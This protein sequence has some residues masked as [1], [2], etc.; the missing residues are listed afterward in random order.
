VSNDKSSYAKNND[1]T[2]S[3]Q[4]SWSLELTKSKINNVD[5][6]SRPKLSSSRLFSQ[7]ES[8]A[9][10]HN[11]HD[12]N[13]SFGVEASKSESLS[14]KSTSLVDDPNVGKLLHAGKKPAATKS[15]SDNNDP[16]RGNS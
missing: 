10:Q 15:K 12:L 13:L 4:P 8:V 3:S 5:H 1:E 2:D 6:S 14:I 16:R 11:D 9:S 7:V